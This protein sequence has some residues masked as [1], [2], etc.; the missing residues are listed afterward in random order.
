MGRLLRVV[1][2]PDEPDP[3][4][5]FRLLALEI[6]EDGVVV[7]YMRIRDLAAPE[8]PEAAARV[9]DGVTI[10]DDVATR[11]ELRGGGAFG[12]EHIAHGMW[13]YA[14]APPT[15]AG[16]LTAT[17]WQGPVDFDLSDGA[18]DPRTASA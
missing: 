18:D 14:P 13:A 16:T 15:G 7:R 5:R 10:S 3:E 4:Q 6:F 17:T 9:W 12:D 2:P 1:L 8:P 11:Y